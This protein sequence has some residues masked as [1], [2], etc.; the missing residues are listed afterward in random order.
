MEQA[1]FFNTLKQKIMRRLA[2]LLLLFVSSTE[3]LNAQNSPSSNATYSD[4]V[5]QLRNDNTVTYVIPQEET[6]SKKVKT[7]RKNGILN[8]LANAVVDIA[9][10]VIE[11]K[12]SNAPS[13][14]TNSNTSNISPTTGNWG[15]NTDNSNTS[16]ISPTTG[17]W[18]TNTDNSS[19]NISPRTGNWGTSSA[20][21]VNTMSTPVQMSTPSGDISRPVQMSTPSGDISRPVELSRPVQ[22]STPSGDIS[23]SV[24]MT[25]PVKNAFTP[26]EMTTPSGDISRPVEMSYSS[27]DMSKPIQLSTLNGNFSTP[28]E[29]SNPVK[30]SSNVTNGFISTEL[31]TPIKLSSSVQF[32]TPIKQLSN[33]KNGTVVNT[34]SS[35]LNQSLDLRGFVPLGWVSQGLDA[36]FYANEL[37]RLSKEAT[38]KGNYA[39]AKDLADKAI[40]VSTK[41]IKEVKIG[42]A[43]DLI[44]VAGGEAFTLV[45][46]A[47]AG[48]KVATVVENGIIKNT[49]V[50]KGFSNLGNGVNNLLKPLGLGSTG[51]TVSNNLVEEIAMRD[52]MTNPQLGIKLREG[53]TDKRWLGWTKME[54]KVKTKEGVNAIV[55]YVGK[56][57]NGILIAVDDFKFK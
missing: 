13:S 53:L 21:S 55:H 2:I 16:N 10:T 7:H 42:A 50:E 15:G 52:A 54:Y 18:G 46:E 23:R 27:G 14:S 30:M 29:L 26:V 4:S 31:S 19:S 39:L 48:V 25:T 47:R 22:M 8:T 32:S 57:K 35:T 43:N 38:A 44:T 34:N 1:K 28:V 33:P 56:W 3:F 45:R 37:T 6:K 49:V 41:G 51:R 5:Q 24:E 36:V 40:A 9:G 20:Q 11:S 17:N 12:L